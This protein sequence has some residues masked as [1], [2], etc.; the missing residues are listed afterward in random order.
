[1]T[2]D[3]GPSPEYSGVFSLVSGVC[4]LRRAWGSGPARRI[5]GRGPEFYFLFRASSSLALMSPSS[6]SQL[7]STCACSDGPP[8][9]PAGSQL[10]W[11]TATCSLPTTPFSA[12][13]LAQGPCLSTCQEKSSQASAGVPE[14]AEPASHTF[15]CILQWGPVAS[16]LQWPG[17]MGVMGTAGKA[18]HQLMGFCFRGS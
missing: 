6:H 11:P 15:T 17:V 8:V 13:R 5:K 12:S 1:M 3:V 16:T 18:R 4:L 7:C 14:T 10:A 2:S 9:L